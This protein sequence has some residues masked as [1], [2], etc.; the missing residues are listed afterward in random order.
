L[1]RFSGK[2]QKRMRTLR[3][4]ENQLLVVD[5]GE[6]RLERRIEGDLE[7]VKGEAVSGYGDLL[8]DR[9]ESF[10]YDLLDINEAIVNFLWVKSIKRS[11]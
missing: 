7:I 6:V 11:E 5:V 1:E 10:S 2:L 4:R 9:F 8:L 3:F